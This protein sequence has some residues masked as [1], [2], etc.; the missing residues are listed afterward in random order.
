MDAPPLFLFFDYVD[1]LSYLTDFVLRDALADAGAPALVR[2]PLELRPPPEPLLD[3]DGPPW[4]ERWRIAEGPA[5]SLGGP[6]RAP[7]LIPWTRKAHELVLHAAAHGVGE[8][9]HREVFEAVFARGDDVGRVDV[10][11]GIAASIGLDR[12][13]AKAVLDVD[14]YAS[15]VVRGR[16]HAERAGVASPPALVHGAAMLRGFLS[17]EALRTFVGLG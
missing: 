8:D 14:R 12:S 15:E 9:A 10:L 2:V 11:V 6:L 4:S 5:R 16:A 17:A 7:R 13:E 3:P 1:P